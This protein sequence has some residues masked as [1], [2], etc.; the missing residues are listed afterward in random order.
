MGIQNSKKVTQVRVSIEFP[1]QFPEYCLHVGGA[2][3]G[4]CIPLTC[5]VHMHMSKL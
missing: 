2:K 3:L 5:C 1:G 4:Y